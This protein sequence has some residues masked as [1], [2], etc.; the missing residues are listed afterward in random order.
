MRSGFDDFALAGFVTS[1]A[2]ILVLSVGDY[3][4]SGRQAR[5][6]EWVSHSHEVRANIART[7][8]DLMELLAIRD[9]D[10]SHASMSAVEAD[11]ARLRE[12]VSDNPP[13]VQRLD[14]IDAVVRP[15]ILN[16]APGDVRA[17]LTTLSSLDGEEQRL[18]EERKREEG[19]TLTWFRLTSGIAIGVMLLVLAALYAMER[20]RLALGKQ[21][22]DELRAEVNQRRLAEDALREFIVSLESVVHE[23]TS[24]LSAAVDELARAKEQLESLAQHDA[25]TGLPNRR[26]LVDRLQ[27]AISG[28]RRRAGHVAVLFVDLDMF[29]AINDTHGHEAGD[30]VLKEV[31]RRLS[32]CVRA[33]DTV[34]R[35]GGDEFVLVLPDLEE[36]E[37]ARRVADKA[38]VELARPMK[39]GANELRVTPSIGVS[40]YPRRRDRAAGAPQVRG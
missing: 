25:L 27:Q 17:A 14:D 10:S 8:S 40:Y 38:L 6:A 12:L 9:P 7:R 20:N 23:R 26:L 29:K 16:L 35:E 33:A 18:L 5:A 2:A 21:A 31:A 22:A 11:L 34:S 39:V 4:A 19:R 36:R 3:W 32:A 1:A 15:H 24:L 37:D 13:Q 28:A 30:E